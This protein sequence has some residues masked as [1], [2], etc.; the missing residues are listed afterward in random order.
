MGVVVYLNDDLGMRPVAMH[1]GLAGVD[2][3]YTYGIPIH[4][5]RTNGKLGDLSCGVINQ[6]CYN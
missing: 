3:L 1:F 2:R 4:C 5:G 6:S